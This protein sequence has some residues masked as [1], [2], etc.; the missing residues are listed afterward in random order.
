MQNLASLLHKKYK[1]E[2]KYCRAVEVI[3]NSWEGVVKNL[4][5]FL[6]P[7]NIYKNEL[8]VECNNSAW[9]S[10]IDYFKATILDHLN[11]LLNEKKI[12][13]KLVGIKVVMNA[14]FSFVNT[15]KPVNFGKTLEER[16]NCSVEIKKKNG[17]KLCQQCQKVWDLSKICRLC[18]L[19]SE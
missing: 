10:E 2:L 12:G 7:K 1:Y 15:K 5:Q 6:Q 13:V 3:S 14:N 4:S 9:V 16:I 8:V 19:T 17:L 11:Q 18:Q